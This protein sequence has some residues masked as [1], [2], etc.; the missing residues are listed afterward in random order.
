MGIL[1]R[2]TVQELKFLMPVGKCLLEKNE[3]TQEVDIDRIAV[4]GS[5]AAAVAPGTRIKLA[6]YNNQI[7]EGEDYP[8]QLLAV[9]E[10]IVWPFGGPD[11][12]HVHFLSPPIHLTPGLYWIGW[13]AYDD[14]WY[15]ATPGLAVKYIT[16]T[17]AEWPN[18]WPEIRTPS[19]WNGASIY[20]GIPEVTLTITRT[21]GGTTDPSP[22]SYPYLVE[23]VVTVTAIP[24]TGYQFDHWELDGVVMTENPI[25]VTM[26]MDHTLY[27]VFSEI[28]PAKGILQV[29]AYVR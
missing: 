24:D 5:S 11:E 20:A 21:L 12:W 8:N 14:I 10:E 4:Y 23:T 26:D 25:D 15:Y 13:K 1:G 2:V 7:I 22:G 19:V 29:H 27:A 9:S 3:L 18:P 6:I 16:Y 17:T 28:P